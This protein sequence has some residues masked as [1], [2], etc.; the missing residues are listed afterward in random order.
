MGLKQRAAGVVFAIAAVAAFLPAASATGSATAPAATAGRVVTMGTAPA[1]DALFHGSTGGMR[2]AQPIVGM[3]ASADGA[4]YWLVASD[5]GIFAFGDARF[6]GSTGGVRLAQPIVGMAATPD[7]GG[8]WL[9]ASDGGIFAFGDA[10]FHGSTGGVRLARPIVGMA[11]SADGAGYW[12]VASDGGIFAFGDARFYGSTGG[13]QLAQPIVGMATSRD[14]AGYWLVAADGGIFTYNPTTPIAPVPKSHF[15]TLPVGAVLPSDATCASEVRPAKE[16]RPANTAANQ[17]R[18]VGGN[19]LYP[20]VTGNYVGTTDEIIQWAACKWGIDEDVVRAQAAVESY[21]FQRTAGDFTTTPSLCVPGHRTLGADGVPG[22][23]PESIGLLQVRYPYHG[24]AFATNDDAAVSTAY[25]IDYAY[26]SWRNCFDGGDG[27]LNTLNP[28]GKHYQ[29]G[30]LWGCVGL[31]FS[32][33][34]YDAG[35]MAYIA[36]VQSYLNERIWETP[37]FLS[38][39]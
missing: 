2:L 32:G 7:G 37:S 4:G 15:S 12:L 17:T 29:A 27:W 10:H 3:A 5:G 38:D 28:P 8:Y 16:V 20:R 22:E 9:V 33:R 11:A 18:G 13:V 31:W 1:H 23:C 25:N 14:V 34:W 24:T 36:K 39:S 26:A 19:S 21:W 30:D 6:Y 35:A